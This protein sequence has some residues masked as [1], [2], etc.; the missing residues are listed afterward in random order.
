ML[1][2]NFC[3]L[4]SITLV[5]SNLLTADDRTTRRPRK[6]DPEERRKSVTRSRQQRSIGSRD[7]DECQE[8]DPLGASYSG[9][10]NVTSSGSSCQVWTASEYPEVGEHNYCRNPD[11]DSGGVWCYTTHP[12]EDW[13]YCS[14]PICAVSAPSI[15]KV[16]DFSADN[17]H[18]P[19]SND[20]LTG[21]TLEAGFLPESFTVCS[22]IMTDA[23]MSVG[24]SAFMFTLLDVDGDDWGLIEL[25]AANSYT[26]YEVWLGPVHI[27]KT[28][29]SMFF[30][31]QWTR[32]CFSLD[33]IASK[34][35]VVD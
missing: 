30:L 8:G 16:L 25:Y 28:I 7:D 5:S 32:A 12:D 21:A 2:S 17:D 4:L 11:G 14:L 15:V 26:E 10:K 34:V 31:L 6:G 33:S 20:E 22:A 29:P 3:L 18:Q 13:E 23:W 9:K 24:V 1:T 35:R 27:I 19:D